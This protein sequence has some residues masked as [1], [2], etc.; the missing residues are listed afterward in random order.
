MGDFCRE[1]AAAYSG[2]IYENGTFRLVGVGDGAA[3][4]GLA[5]DG[6]IRLF[7]LW[8]AQGLGVGPIVSEPAHN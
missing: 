1:N 4:F 8:S 2:Y 6:E 5:E 3:W 7:S